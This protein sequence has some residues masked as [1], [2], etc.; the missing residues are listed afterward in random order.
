M[1]GQEIAIL[2]LDAIKEIRLLLA[3]SYDLWM[4]GEHGT[5]SRCPGFL[6]ADDHKRRF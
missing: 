6:C 3:R 4:L 1:I 2:D 5:E